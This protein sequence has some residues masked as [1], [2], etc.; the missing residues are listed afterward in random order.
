MNRAYQNCIATNQ[1]KQ[2]ICSLTL[3][4]MSYTI[5]TICMLHIHYNPTHFRDSV[6]YNCLCVA[7]LSSILLCSGHLPYWGRNASFSL[8][9]IFSFP[10]FPSTSSTISFCFS[11]NSLI[12]SYF[13]SV[14]SV[15]MSP[16]IPFFN[17]TLGND[18]GK[19]AKDHRL[20]NWHRRRTSG[21]QD[22][23]GK[24]VGLVGIC[25]VAVT[26][27]DEFQRFLH[28]VDLNHGLGTNLIIRKPVVIL[29]DSSSVL[30]RYEFHCTSIVEILEPLGDV[31]EYVFYVWDSQTI[32]VIGNKEK[33]SS[34]RNAS[35][36]DQKE[37]EL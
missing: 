36:Q 20:K 3:F 13:L 16:P 29:K 22:G 32:K 1:E 37:A 28:G 8:A 2:T 24:A 26:D 9:D 33:K 14:S 7:Q 21:E 12:L 19:S 15:I 35:E 30:Y 5:L 31:S 23:S 6:L 25:G 4:I 11:L 17:S 10:H 27:R 18:L 34:S